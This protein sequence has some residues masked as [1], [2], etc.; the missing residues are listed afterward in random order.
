[1]HRK[2]KGKKQKSFPYRESCLLNESCSTRTIQ[3][4][5]LL[6]ILKLLQWI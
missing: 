1:M 5:M 3:V 2:I 6:K 4:V